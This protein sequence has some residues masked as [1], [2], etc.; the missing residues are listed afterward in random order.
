MSKAKFEEFKD[1]GRVS[2]ERFH[3]D[4]IRSCSGDEWQILE[5]YQ[6]GNDEDL[7]TQSITM[8]I[9]GLDKEILSLYCDVCTGN[10]T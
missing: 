5:M 7:H 1:F 9:S 4:S 8:H 2:K 6:S 10:H 3:L